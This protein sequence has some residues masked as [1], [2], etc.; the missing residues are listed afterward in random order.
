[1]WS[2]AFDI[3]SADLRLFGSGRFD[4]IVEKTIPVKFADASL[5]GLDEESFVHETLV[6]MPGIREDTIRAFVEASSVSRAIDLGR[7]ERAYDARAAR[8]NEMTGILEPTPDAESGTVGLMCVTNV[9]FSTDGSQALVFL[10]SWR[11]NTPNPYRWLMFFRRVENKWAVAAI[12]PA[13][14]MPICL[15]FRASPL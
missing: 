5:D 4:L 15:P 12:R 2:A 3:E 10:H 13:W 9:G 1:M 6:A 8:P 14:D 11:V 7:C